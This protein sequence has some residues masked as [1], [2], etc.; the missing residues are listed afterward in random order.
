MHSETG[1]FVEDPRCERIVVAFIEFI[2]Q[3]KLSCKRWNK[4]NI[5]RLLDWTLI[6]LLSG[7][8]CVIIILFMDFNDSEYVRKQLNAIKCTK[9]SHK[10]KQW[11]PVKMEFEFHMV[12]LIVRPHVECHLTFGFIKQ[13]IKTHAIENQINHE[14]AA[15][16]E[17][18]HTPALYSHSLFIPFR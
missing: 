17:H 12:L 10:I 7:T 8:Q 3:M 11:N 18:T 9:L 1:L 14:Q 13:S 6:W 15:D 16:P 4:R 2:F 5:G